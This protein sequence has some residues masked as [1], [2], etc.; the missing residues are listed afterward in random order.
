VKTRISLSILLRIICGLAA[1]PSKAQ[2]PN[3]GWWQWRLTTDNKTTNSAGL[4]SFETKIYH[5]LAINTSIPTATPYCTGAPDPSASASGQSGQGVGINT[6]QVI[7]NPIFTFAFQVPSNIG[8]VQMSWSNIGQDNEYL[9]SG[10]CRGDLTHTATVFC[11]THSCKGG[12][13]PVLVDTS[14][15]GFFLTD[16]AHGVKFDIYANGNPIQ[17]GWASGVDNGFLALPG[18]DGLVHNGSQLFGTE[19][20]SANRNGFAALAVYDDPENGGNGDGVIDAKDAVY[21]SLRIWIDSNH[22]GVS[23]PGE[24]HTLASLGINSISLNYKEGD[25]TD[26]FGN[27]FKYWTSVDLGDPQQSVGRKAVDVFFVSQ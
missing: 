23:Q 7:C 1:N 15:Q 9:T 8:A 16:A 24:L 10:T 21:K 5:V 13:C 3:C 12:T 18:L 26:Q 17:M 22:D 27:L 20:P 2:A 6:P 25:G 4:I 11:P 19:P 14:G